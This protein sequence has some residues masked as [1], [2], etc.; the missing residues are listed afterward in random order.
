MNKHILLRLEQAE[1]LGQM[2]TCPRGQVGAVIFEPYSW[3]VVADGYNG[4]P[5][6]GGELCG[7]DHCRRDLLEIISGSMTETGCHH[8][9]SN[10]I[11]NAAR[12][13]APT[14]GA[15]LAVT[16]APCLSC[17]KIVHHAGIKR[18]FVFACESEPNLSGVS[19]LEQHQV[20][21]EYVERVRAI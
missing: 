16:R 15:W 21:V 6:G 1:L 8:A 2:S 18:V 9:E 19:Y 17:A 7:E 12:R 4:P 13:G 10:A 3:V 11:V 5:R 20:S 14:R